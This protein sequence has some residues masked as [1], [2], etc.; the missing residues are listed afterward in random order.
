MYQDRADD[1]LFIDTEAITT[2]DLKVLRIQTSLS[3]YSKSIAIVQKRFK[4]KLEKLEF[5]LLDVPKI[6]VLLF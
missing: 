1:I 4:S 5:G 3:P 2:F 6:Y